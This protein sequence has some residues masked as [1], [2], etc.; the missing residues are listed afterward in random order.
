MKK[1]LLLYA[2]SL[3]LSYTLAMDGRY[4]L[5]LVQAANETEIKQALEKEGNIYTSETTSI[6]TPLNENYVLN[7]YWKKIKLSN[8]ETKDAAF[9]KLLNLDFPDRMYP[10]LRRHIGAAL[11]A[12]ANPHSADIAD[13]PLHN[14]AE[15]QDYALCELLF[16]R[17]VSPNMKCLDTPVIFSVKTAN[18]ANLF[19]KYGADITIADEDGNN[20]LHE[21]ADVEFEPKLISLYKDK[22]LSPLTVDHFPSNTTCL[23]MLALNAEDYVKKN[24]LTQLKDKISHIFAGL[25]PDDIIQLLNI[26]QNEHGTIFDILQKNND[27]ASKMFLAQLRSIQDSLQGKK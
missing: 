7:D 6:D 12:G 18:L 11:R 10:L 1:V 27:L 21:A 22:G 24:K 17:K 14:A 20:L 13:S 16:E 5:Q 3:T 26:R 25:K 19:L 23:H 4:Y 15:F 9:A 8:Q 2:V